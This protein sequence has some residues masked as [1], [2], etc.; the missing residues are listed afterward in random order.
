MKP[1]LWGP[2][3]FGGH[4]HHNMACI[5]SHSDVMK[6]LV[7][8]RVLLQIFTKSASPSSRKA[9]SWELPNQVLRSEGFRVTK[10]NSDTTRKPR[11]NRA[12]GRGCHPFCNLVDIKAYSGFQEKGARR[13]R[14]EDRQ[15][16]P[17]LFVGLNAI[18][19]TSF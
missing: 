17:K 4:L 1:S 11:H 2:I 12:R 9:K 16:R 13:S 19:G 15:E 7:L 8:V 14:K 10:Q 3:E 5:A 6:N 18:S